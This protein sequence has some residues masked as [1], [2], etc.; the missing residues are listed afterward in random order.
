MSETF[1][2][3]EP[4]SLFASE[5][6]ILKFWQ[7]QQIFA[8]SLKK[9]PV[10]QVFSFYDGP[11]FI[12]GLPH[13][14]TL[15]PSIA[16]D[17]IPRYQTMKGKNVRRKWGWDVHGL[18]AENQVE[19]Q[20]GLKGK[21]DIER[22]GI[23]K[24]V[25][26][27]R[28]YVNS[29]SKEWRWYIDHIGRWADMDSAYRTD[30]LKY[31]ESVM[32]AFKQLYDQGL[33]YQGRRVS[34]YCTRCATPL[35]KFEITMEEG[36]Y[37]DV[38]DPAVTVAFPVVGD[39]FS[40]VAWTT[41]PWTLPA[42]LALAVDPQA[43]YV[44]VSD[45]RK[46]F[47]LAHQALVRYRDLDWEIIE[48]F[49]GEKL[50]GLE[51]E[52]LYQFFKTNPERDHRIYPAT[53]VS[54][55]EGTGIVHIAPGFGEQDTQLGEEQGLSLLLT[56]DEVGNFVPQVE[57]WAGRYVK[58]ADKDIINDLEKRSLLVKNETI[59]HAYPH[60]YRCGTPLIYKS[61]VSW[62]LSIEPLRSELLSKNKQ[63]NWVPEHFGSGRFK[64][65]LE[66][67]P[68]WSLSRTRYWGSPIPVWQTAE[69]TKIVVGSI[70]ELEELSSQ[71]ITDLHRPFI[72][73]LVLTT[74]DGQQAHRVKEVLDCW[75]ESGAMPYA[76]DHYP[77]ENE[78][79]FKRHFPADFIIEHTGQLRGWFYYLHVLGTALKDSISFKNVVVSGVLAG[80]DGRKMSKSY[81]NYP[82]PRATIEKYGGESL[83]LYF[84]SSK[85]IEGEDLSINEEEIR[86]QSRLLNVLHN[87]FRYFLTYANLHHFQI[88]DEL[89]EK[90][91]LD[92]WLVARLEE[93]KAVYSEGLDKFQLA[94]STRAIR[95][96]IE[97]LSTWYIRRSRERFVSG[98]LA[99]LQTLYTVLRQFSL[100]VAPT[101][102][103]SAEL[104]YRTLTQAEGEQ[105]VHLEDY[106]QINKVL[107]EES[108]ELLAMMSRVRLI[109]SIVHRLR[110]EQNLSLRQ[111]LAAVAIEGA[112]D[113]GH[114]E[115]LVTLLKEEANVSQVTFGS[116]P[117][118][119]VQTEE[120]ELKI[121]L[122]VRLNNELKAEGRFREL[123][124]QLQ[125]ARKKVGLKVGEKAK[126]AYFTENDELKKLIA[127][128]SSQLAEAVNLAEVKLSEG[129]NELEPIVGED[130][131]GRFDND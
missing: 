113:L 82:D 29:S 106:P 91:V 11:P 85:I 31:M 38:E 74:K 46:N 1:K 116:L 83:R 44:K 93:F 56:V 39:D 59:T 28:D 99:A 110:A 109:A 45:G 10:D 65:N 68:D 77:F 53:F 131:F 8:K 47:V 27:C 94:A 108:Q 123:V 64:H 20:L 125:D 32:H 97:D 17:I 112:N 24:F 101:L 124:R 37:R 105:S 16:K 54:M 95:P 6:A 7:D 14:A 107:A 13:H 42:N 36:N 78:T 84:M 60:C 73:D 111:P 61:Q 115:A 25:A 18:P 92:R 52:P 66:T 21:A 50:I 2:L 86:Q 127:E 41:T 63:I 88:T 130:L 128:R 104:I 114:Q 98:D 122:D 35:S 102:P 5:E 126:L 62:Y 119:F 118:G 100:A 58:A 43:E 40:L 9:N 26:A 70:K 79:E 90:T 121:G 49:K 120:G 15:L 87:S 80:N 69:G 76:Q 12:T 67:A 19:K 33:I 48:A 34:L 71:K 103:F 57:P 75:F 23:D 72:D 81:G 22:L 89:T 129:N 30:D 51:Y 3:P 4:L 55:E 96:F 117:D